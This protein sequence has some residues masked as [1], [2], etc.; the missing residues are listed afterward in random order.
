MKKTILIILNILLLISCTNV[1]SNNTFENLIKNYPHNPK[2]IKEYE[3]IYNETNNIIYAINMVNYP[4]FL[5]PNKTSYLSFK[6]ENIHFVNT[7]YRLNQN[8]IPKD[9]TEIT[10]VD[11]IKRTDQKI[12]VNKTV[13]DAYTKM[14][15]DSLNENLHLTIFSAYRSYEYQESLYN[16]ENNDYVAP[17]GASEHQTGYA[18]DIS[19]KDTGLTYHFENTD[20]YKWLKENSY[21]YGFI[22]RY[23]KDKETITGYPFEPWH[24]TYVGNEAAKIIYDNN[25]TLEEYFYYYII[26]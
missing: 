3:Q 22:E 21:I 16:K 10:N 2:K 24:Y 9:L 11:I 6:K 20:E 4:D 8:Y 12:E 14:F 17:P 7:N 1:T 26:L 15:K 5:I 23:K 19:T 13:L 25:L 18:I